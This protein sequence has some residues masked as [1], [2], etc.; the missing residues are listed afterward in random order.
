MYGIL[1]YGSAAK[2]N[3]V[4]IEK[5]QRRIL[6]AIFFMQRKDSLSEIFTKKGVLT[7]FELFLVELTKELFKQIRL[8]YTRN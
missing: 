7:V 1:V 6:R 2:T 4:K 3:L 5:A 8:E